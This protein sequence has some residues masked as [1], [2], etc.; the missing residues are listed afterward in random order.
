MIGNR[1][2]QPPPAAEGGGGG[3]GR[4]GGG[5]TSAFVTPASPIIPRQDEMPQARALLFTMD[6]IDQYVVNSKRGGASGEI[7]IRDALVR[8]L[9]GHLNVEVDVASSDG[10]F[11]QLS[12]GIKKGRYA[13][14]VLDAWTWAARGKFSEP[15]KLELKQLSDR[16]AWTIR[17]ILPSFYH[18]IALSESPN[19]DVVCSLI[20]FWKL[21]FFLIR[22]IK[23]G[24]RNGRSLASRIRCFCWTSLAPKAPRE[25]ASR[26]RRRGSSQL[27]R[28]SRETPS[29]AMP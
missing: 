20:N 9:K 21:A 19:C 17:F 7:T 6:S 25:T 1:P 13:F 26:S 3:G 29:S 4:G 8:H 2:Q 15:K 11:E 16:L 23:A 14:A 18:G 24:C 28:P 27:F 5:G 10:H 12:A 22:A